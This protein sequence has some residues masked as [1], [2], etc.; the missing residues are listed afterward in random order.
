MIM[1][2]HL[3]NGA[4]MFA[5]VWALW[6]DTPGM[7]S[8]YGIDAPTRRILDCVYLAIG[9]INLYAMGRTALGAPDIAAQIGL[10]LFPLR[11][12]Y[13][14]KTVAVVGIA[15]TVVIANLMVVGLHVATQLVVF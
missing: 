6:R 7:A 9:L 13:K 5:V 4:V 1:L 15:H 14:A 10:T 2:S 3:V 11:I 12:L 8:A